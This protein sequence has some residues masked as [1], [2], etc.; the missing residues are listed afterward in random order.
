MIGFSLD[1]KEP[2]PATSHRRHENRD[3]ATAAR[4]RRRP[5]NPSA[6]EQHLRDIVRTSLEGSQN[7]SHRFVEDLVVV[8][9]ETS[10]GLLDFDAAWED[11]RDS[12]LD[13]QEC[14]DR[15]L[16]RA[17]IAK[18]DRVRAE[19]KRIEAVVRNR[20]NRRRRRRGL[21]AVGKLRA[22]LVERYGQRMF[23]VTH[24]YNMDLDADDRLPLDTQARGA[25]HAFRTRTLVLARI[26]AGASSRRS[27][28][29]KYE[30]ALVRQTVDTLICVPVFANEGAWR[31][32]ASS[33]PEPAGVFCLD[34]DVD[35]SDDFNDPQIRHL[36]ATESTVLFPA[37]NPE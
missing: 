7:L 16:R 15:H 19:L 37:L 18:P 32:R 36:L 12:F 29:T 17:L 6:F 4:R 27:V 21:P 8:S 22:N 34:S 24:A 26:G 28:M 3:G 33:R 30:R 23:R 14:A 31:R 35:L 20:L 2:S 11:L 10:L 5:L 9:L 25:P 1:G 13:G